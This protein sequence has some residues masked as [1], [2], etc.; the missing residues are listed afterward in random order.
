MYIFIHGYNNYN[1]TLKIPTKNNKNTIISNSVNKNNGNFI[2]NYWVN[3][4]EYTH[5]DHEYPKSQNTYKTNLKTMNL[6]IK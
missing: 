1:L 6:Q 5:Y 4:K 3:E 2:N